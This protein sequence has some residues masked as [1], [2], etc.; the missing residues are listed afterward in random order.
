MNKAALLEEYV[1]QWRE[2]AFDWTTSTCIDFANGWLKEVESIDTLARLPKWEGRTG[3]IR[4][5]AEYKTLDRAITTELRRDPIDPRM[6]QLGDLVMYPESGIGFIGICN[7]MKAF[8]LHK[9]VGIGTLS[10]EDAVWAWRTG[11]RP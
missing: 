8:M 5:I 11:A 7:G 3:A 4:A 6:A 2:R 1:A 10:M 9:T